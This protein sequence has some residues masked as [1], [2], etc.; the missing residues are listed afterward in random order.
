M[1]HSQKQ[2]SHTLGPRINNW[3][4]EN[5]RPDA[6]TRRQPPAPWAT[7][8]PVSCTVISRVCCAVG[9]WLAMF[10]DRCGSKTNTAT[11][12]AS[13][14]P[15]KIWRRCVCG[16]VAK[17]HRAEMPKAKALYFD[18]TPS[19]K[20]KPH[21]IHHKVARRPLACAA[22]QRVSMQSAQHK[23][24]GASVVT[25]RPNK[26]DTRVAEKSPPAKNG[27]SHAADAIG[28]PTQHPSAED[29][30]RH[31][32]CFDTQ[33]RVAKQG[34]GYLDEGYQDRRLGEIAPLQVTR[35]QPILGLVHMQTCA[36]EGEFEHAQS[37]QGD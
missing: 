18:N 7:V 15:K 3:P 28:Q 22:S 21:A 33:Q 27:G 26:P 14:P 1:R 6:N 25:L 19:P 32:Q 9:Q 34:G 35:P 23:V 16:A 4:N 5:S 36:T 8:E 11:Q 20:L 24:R 37:Q 31:R 2:T 29:P 12:L 17:T 30:A 10:Q 13:K